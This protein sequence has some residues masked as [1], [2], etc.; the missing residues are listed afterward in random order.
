MGFLKDFWSGSLPSQNP[1]EPTEAR[2]PR[3]H[4]QSETAKTAMPCGPPSPPATS[5]RA[6]VKQYSEEI[7]A[8]LTRARVLAEDWTQAEIHNEHLILS[9]L[10]CR[11]EFQQ[12]LEAMS[13][14]TGGL[15]ALCREIA[16][17]Y[18]EMDD[19]ANDDVVMGDDLFGTLGRA[20][21]F[22]DNCSEPEMSSTHYLL[23]LAEQESRI[24]QYIAQFVNPA[25]QQAQGKVDL[26]SL[27]P[28]YSEEISSGL[29]NAQTV[30]AEW[31]QTEIHNEHLIFALC[32]T[33]GNFS[34]QLARTKIRPEDLMERLLE[35]MSKYPAVEGHVD[36][37]RKIG[38]DLR[39]T[40]AE[41]ELFRLKTH[42]DK[43][44]PIHYLMA[45]IEQDGE[46]AQYIAKFANEAIQEERSGGQAG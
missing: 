5:D 44:I 29:R 17:E 42:S 32:M 35:K 43:L 40:L 13:I 36:S 3:I 21:R 9:L 12:A 2:P 26:E 20:Q 7:D 45:L 15:S 34:A 31:N 27:P 18:R 30:T 39:K 23:A 22:R 19:S 37:T 33:K 4:T 24:G 28:N 16:G 46:I 10:R 14:G 8:A 38:P 41:A 11:G 25:L 6:G 1:G